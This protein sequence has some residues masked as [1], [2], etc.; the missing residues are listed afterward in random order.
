LLCLQVVIAVLLLL[1]G[2]ACD[3]R[4][5]TI[6]KVKLEHALDSAHEED[7][8]LEAWWQY[9]DMLVVQ[10]RGL[11]LEQLQACRANY[12]AARNHT[13]REDVERQLQRDRLQLDCEA[14]LSWHSVRPQLLAELRHDTD[15]LDRE[16][17]AG[18]D[19]QR[20]AQ[21][22]TF[23]RVPPCVHMLLIN[24]PMWFPQVRH[25]QLLS[26]TGST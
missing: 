23:V 5:L 22:V 17:P 8:V 19:A 14:L 26:V 15:F 11:S 24:H 2:L 13:E 10:R 18:F 16:F 9:L 3:D 1:Y 7:A 25:V 12:L 20:F 6:N 21:H 4:H